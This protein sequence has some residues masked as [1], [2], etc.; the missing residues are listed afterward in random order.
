MGLDKARGINNIVDMGILFIIGVLG[1]LHLLGDMSPLIAFAV[2]GFFVLCMAFGLLGDWVEKQRP[3]NLRKT[4][5]RQK[6]TAAQ[7]R[8][9][10]GSPPR[11]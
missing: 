8:S 11:S 7:L 9:R 1:L 2:M 3:I 6:I 4:A 10:A 5:L